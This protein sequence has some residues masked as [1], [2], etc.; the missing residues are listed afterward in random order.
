MKSSLKSLLFSLLIM[1][2]LG[3]GCEYQDK[4]SDYYNFKV[5][6]SDGDF[7]GYYVVDAGSFN[8]F[9]GS[10]VTGTI[11]WTYEKNLESPKSILIKVTAKD[12]N[13]SGISVY[14]YQNSELVA[15]A[16]GTRSYNATTG[17]YDKAIVS[18]SYTFT[19]TTTT[20]K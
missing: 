6:A 18:L 14:V 16:D 4:E 2:F 20:T 15:S 13:A 7:T 17:K 8:Y 1:T 19:T 3:A 9:T 10:Q 11:Y 12:D 5:M